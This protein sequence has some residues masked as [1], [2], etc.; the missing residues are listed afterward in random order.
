MMITELG[1]VTWSCEYFNLPVIC[2][3]W[4]W[5]GNLSTRQS[6]KITDIFILT[7]NAMNGN[8]WDLALTAF[9]S[10]FCDL[11]TNREV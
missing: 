9:V 8:H 10:L 11:F 4:R 3:T 7:G 1:S 2:Y 5:S 6:V